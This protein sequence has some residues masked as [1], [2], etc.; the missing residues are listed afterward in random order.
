MQQQWTPINPREP[1]ALTHEM[2]QMWTHTTYALA[3]CGVENNILD[4]T[5]EMAKSY[6]DDRATF[7]LRL[8]QFLVF[9][10]NYISNEDNKTRLTNT[11]ADWLN[12]GN[13]FPFEIRQSLGFD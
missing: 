4:E 2:E 11:V 10:N 12:Q 6:T 13:Q 8:S 3:E 1:W 5:Y 7:G 9:F